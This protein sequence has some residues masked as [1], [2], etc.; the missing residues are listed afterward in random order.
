MIDSKDKR[1]LELEK[2]NDR[3]T[4]S[5]VECQCDLADRLNAIESD[6]S[7]AKKTIAPKNRIDQ[8]RSDHYQ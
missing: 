7:L 1:I 3:L 8:Y 6:I 5:L 2:E 4:R